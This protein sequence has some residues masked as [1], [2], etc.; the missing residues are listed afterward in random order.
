MK[1]KFEMSLMGELTFF[2]GLQVKQKPDGIFISQDKY[3]AK[4]SRKFGL[5]DKK[6]ACS[7]ID[8]EKPLLKDPDGEDI[9]VH[10]YRSM[11]GSLMY[12]NLSRLDIMF[13]VRACAH[14]Q[15]TLKV[16]HLHAVKRIF[17]YLKGKLHL[18]LWYPKDS[19]FNLVAYSDS[20]YAGTSLDR[21]STTWGCQFLGCR[22]ISWQCKKQ[23]VVSTSSTEVRKGFSRVETHFFEGM[24]V[25]QQ[26]D[27]GAS[28]VNVADEVPAGV[29]VDE[30]PTG[31][32]VDVVPAA[33]DKPS[34][35]SP[36][37]TN[38]PPPSS[39]ELP[40]T[41]QGEIIANMDADEDVILKDV[42][43][44]A[45][46]E[47]DADVQGRQ[48]EFQARI[49]KIDLEHADK[50]RK[51]FSRVETHFFKGMI[52]AQQ[53]DEGAGG[54]N[55]ADEV[56][57][58]VNVDEV[59]TGV[60]VDVVPAATDKP[61]IPSPTP[62]NQPPP[63]S[64]ELPS[65]SQKLEWRNKLKVS[66][67]RRLKKVGT[68]QRVDTSE[69][70]V[71][72]D[73]SK[74]GEIIANMDADEDV[75]LKDVAKDAEVEKDADVQ[76]RQAEF[77]ARIY[78]IDLEHADKTA[79]PSIIIHSEPKSKD[80][81]KRIMV[82]EP[83]PLKK[84]TQ[85]EQNEAYAKELEAELNKN[86][87]WDDVIE[88]VQRKEKEDNVVLR[89]QA[90][91]RK[92]QTKAQAKKN[93]MIYLRNMAGFKIDYFNGMSYDD[94][95]PIFEK[96]FISNVAFMEKTKEHIED[97]DSRALKR[98]V[99]S[100]EEKA[101]KMQNLH[102]ERRYPLT[103]FTL[104]QMLNNVQLEVEEESE[105]SLKLLRFVRQQQQEGFRPE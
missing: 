99:E 43:K 95:R 57:A 96:Y 44:D 66:K 49:Y 42:A 50:V 71:M 89:Y 65:T 18:S 1:D 5:T 37:P 51:G 3:V 40:S 83:K 12:L 97:E 34:I 11:I 19:P 77:Q 13:A 27:E 45:E 59:P 79:T 80:K 9:D 102:Q 17:R 55:V 87:N 14:F 101:A 84:K 32:D 53:A 15:V 88:Q 7:P 10:T 94:I 16:S 62:T 60:D 23:T 38:Q 33:T 90:L 58:G 86:I 54:V 20:D 73:V 36:A 56:P 61:S 4:I 70:I 76:G 2:L 48:A 29:N 93:M 105:V 26:A 81:G 92:P 8:T 98:K 22:L 28:G 68:A 31:V 46:V 30:V 91:K 64:Q 69:D 103:R 63:S 74:Q 72:D 6:S 35:P 52:V 82:Q 100:S 41:S 24:I 78:K 67:L 75:I 25:A 47:K 85:I 21:K 104:D 39:Q